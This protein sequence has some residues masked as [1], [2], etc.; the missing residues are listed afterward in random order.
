[1]ANPLICQKPVSGIVA[2]LEGLCNTRSRLVQAIAGVSAAQ[3]V[4]VQGRKYLANMT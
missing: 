4:C 1:V 3:S 2:D